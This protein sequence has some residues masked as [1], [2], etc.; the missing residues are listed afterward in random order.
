MRTSKRQTVWLVSMLGLMVVL[1]A[2][3]LFTDPVDDLQTAGEQNE[4]ENLAMDISGGTVDP[5]TILDEIGMTKEDGVA[6]TDE[7]ILAEFEEAS[8]TMSQD[9]FVTS[10]MERL[11]SYNEQWDELMQ[12]I[13]DPNTSDEEMTEAYETLGKLEEQQTILEDLEQQLL[14]LNFENVFI[15]ADGEGN[16]LVTVKA[17]NVEKSQFVSIMDMVTEELGVHAADVKVQHRS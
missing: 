2:Y 5:E 10:Y 8:E 12:V 9:F 11:E 17:D 6:K 7:E 3:Y 14:S 4:T 15:S 13:N 1:S 16:Y